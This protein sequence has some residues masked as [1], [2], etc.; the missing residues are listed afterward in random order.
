M[1]YKIAFNDLIVF[2][3]VLFFLVSCERNCEMLNTSCIDY[4]LIPKNNVLDS[5]DLQKYQIRDDS[6]M[7]LANK[8]V[9][10]QGHINWH[11]NCNI[12]I[13]KSGYFLELRN[14]SDTTDWR[15]FRIYEY[16]R[17]VIALE[18]NSQ[19]KGMQKLYDDNSHKMDSTLPRAA[20]FKALS[21][22]DILDAEWS[23]DNSYDSYIEV[24]KIDS[25]SKLIEGNFDLYFKL[26][27]QST[28]PNV[29]YA[30]KAQFRCG[31]FR[32]KI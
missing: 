7:A 27:S 23:I 24:I 11:S 6:S 22:G 29:N 14:Y 25:I 32:V 28:R 16:Q 8:L 2:I 21:D 31:K 13:N 3:T 19:S 9:P 4:S 26:S 30:D 1:N 18:C 15:N 20:Y 17:E 12:G 10:R 5:P